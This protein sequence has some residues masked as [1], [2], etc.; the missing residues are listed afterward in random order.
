MGLYSLDEPYR[1]STWYEYNGAYDLNAGTDLL[2]DQAR[3]IIDS[4]AYMFQGICFPKGDDVNIGFQQTFSGSLNLIPYSYIISIN[5]SCK[6]QNYTLRI[7]DKGAQ[8]DLY[9]G[10][11]AWY[12]T[13][14][15]NA[16]Q[17]NNGVFI[18]DG[19]QD[20]PISPYLFRDPLI[21]LPPGVLQVQITNTQADPGPPDQF[22]QVFL[23]VAVPKSTMSLNNRKVLSSTDQTGIQSAGPNLGR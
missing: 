9:Y 8:T 18:R 3:H 21:V 19:E 6:S 1:V 15:G 23:N 17:P 22:V 16:F 11:F 12:P 4:D 5:G 7:F 20:K 10:Q 14:I 13:V 2:I